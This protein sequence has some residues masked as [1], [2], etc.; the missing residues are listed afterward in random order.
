MRAR[1][2]RR[3]ALL[4]VFLASFPPSTC[5]EDQL[6]AQVSAVRWQHRHA[7]GRQRTLC[8]NQHLCSTSHNRSEGRPPVR[9]RVGLRLKGLASPHVSSTQTTGTA[10]RARRYLDD[11]CMY[12]YIY[13]HIYICV[14]ED[15]CDMCMYI[16][17]YIYVHIYMC[18]CVCVFICI[19]ICIYTYIYIYMYIYIHIYICVCIYI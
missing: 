3:A 2:C 18:V 19:Y 6:H 5:G 16:Y 13:V 11:M 17:I 15:T 9:R 14:H 10:N 8:A 12:I 1:Q 7:V 4:A